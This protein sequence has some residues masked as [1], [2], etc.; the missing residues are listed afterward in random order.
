MLGYRYALT[1]YADIFASAGGVYINGT[2]RDT[3]MPV[4]HFGIESYTPTTAISVTAGHDLVI[5]PS[6]A[7]PIIG[8]I[9]EMGVVQQWQKLGGHFR[10]GL[11][12]NINA[13]NAS[14]LGTVGWGGEVGID[15]SFTTNLKLGLAAMRD[16]RLYDPTVA[17]PMVDLDVVQLRLTWE[18]ARFE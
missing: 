2:G 3:G 8:D 16:A 17:G 13:F 7:G 1:P 5:G 15:W 12:R 4:A 9:A 6:S 14:Q 18:K 10:I 11:Y